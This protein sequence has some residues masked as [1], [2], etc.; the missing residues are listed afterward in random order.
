MASGAEAALEAVAE[1]MGGPA[2]ETILFENRGKHLV[3]LE[4]ILGLDPGSVLDVGGGLGVN[5]LCLRRL[6]GPEPRLVLVDRFREYDEDNRMGL[7]SRGLEAMERAGV[8][9]R[10]LSFWPEAELPA[11]EGGYDVVTIFDVLEHLP[12]HPLGLLEACRRVLSPGGALVLGGPNAVALGRRIKVLRGVHPYTPYE[13]W[14]GDRYDG[15]YREYTPAEYADLLER[16]GFRVV[17]RRAVAEP[18]RTRARH[19]YHQGHH[20]RLSPTAAALWGMRLLE[21]LAPD[22]RGSVYLVARPEGPS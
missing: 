15:H 4:L 18:T 8:E 5:L 12:G 13:L 6:L 1:E 2:R 22:L 9:A 3:E 21:G 20:G 16:A 11:Q 17:S 7:A 19:A 14:L 10:E